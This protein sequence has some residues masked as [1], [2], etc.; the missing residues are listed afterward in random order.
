MA[1][2]QCSGIEQ[3]FDQKVADQDL[4]RYLN[5]GPDKTTQMLIDAVRSL[6][7][8]DQTLLDIG[9]GVG[10]ISHELLKD[11]VTKITHVEAS[12]AYYA[13]AKREAERRGA[14]DRFQYFL[15]DFVDLSETIP[16]ADIVTLDRVICCYHDMRRLV[17]CS[18]RLS[19]NFYALVYPRDTWWMKAF[20]SIQNLFFKWRGSPFRVYVHSVGEIDSGIKERGFQLLSL[21]KTFTWEVAIYRRSLSQ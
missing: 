12:S 8:V 6:G 7:L 10:V 15:G 18:T 21:Q 2:S 14:A 20:T 5:R 9:G 16:A 13:A 3:Y 11:G 4:Q 19:K 1:C 17:D